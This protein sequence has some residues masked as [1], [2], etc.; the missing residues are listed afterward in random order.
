MGSQSACL[1]RGSEKELLNMLKIKHLNH[2][3]VRRKGFSYFCFYDDEN[4]G[5]SM[6]KINDS[7]QTVSRMLIKVNSIS[8][9]LHSDI[10][11]DIEEFKKIYF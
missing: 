5:F 8:E 7:Q 9:F 1:K 3:H 2:F 11:S 10:I 6:F 4:E